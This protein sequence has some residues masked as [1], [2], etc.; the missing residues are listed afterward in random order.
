MLG[1]VCF[2]CQL[3]DEEMCFQSDQTAEPSSMFFRVSYVPLLTLLEVS[4]EFFQQWFSLYYS[5][6]QLRLMKERS[7]SC[8][9][10]PFHLSCGTL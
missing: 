7:E 3:D 2:M 4:C 1:M 5:G 9:H 8:M 10:N 6:I